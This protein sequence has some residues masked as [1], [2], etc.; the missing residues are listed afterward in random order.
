VPRPLRN[1]RRILFRAGAALIVLGWAPLAVC[2]ALAAVTG[3]PGYS[4]NPVGLGLL[5]TAVGG[6]GILLLIVAF[7]LDEPRAAP[8]P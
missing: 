7:C 5:G 2:C 3:D 1:W 8:P 6:P 4:D